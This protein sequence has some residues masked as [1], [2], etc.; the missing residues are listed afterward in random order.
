MGTIFFNAHHS[1]IGAFASF[2][3]G[4]CG[5]KGGLGLELGKPANENLY[6]GAETR[7]GGTFE[8]LPFFAEAEDESKRYD[9]EAQGKTAAKAA[10]RPF[11]RQDIRR[12]FRLGTDTWKA[13]DLTFR[14]LSPVT[15]VPDPKTAGDKEMKRAI[16]PAVLA[17]LTLDNSAGRKPRQVFFGYQGS[18][19]YSSMRRLD[20]TAAGAF[21]GI[22]QGRR[23]AIVS[24][25]PGTVSCLGFTMESIL[26]PQIAANLVFGLGGTGAVVGVV[27]PRQTRTFRFAVCF[28]RDGYCT[29]GIDCS[30]W[31]TRYFANIEAVA[32]YALR[33][34]AKLATT[35]ETANRMVDKAKLSPDQKFQLRHAIRSYYGSTEFLDWDGKPFWVVNEGE[36]R[37]M[38]TFDL[39]A[40]QLF[41]ELRMNPWT[42]RNELAMFLKRFSYFD[43]V[44]APGAEKAH[45]GGLSFTHDMGVANS[46]S[47]PHY[48]SYEL[49]GL[50]GCFSHMTHEQLC[51]WVL[52][53]TSYYAVTRDTKWLKKHLAVL[54]ACFQSLLNRDHH[55]PKRRDGVM[56]L[57]S[58][59]CQGGAEITTYD[60]LDTSLGQSRNNLYMAVKCW[61]CY[62]ALEKLFARARLPTLA[63]ESASQ[64]RRCA[65]TICAHLTDKGYIPAVMGEGNDSKII[66]A[67]EGLV[68]P[69]IQ[70]HREAL[71]PKGRF[72]ALMAALRQHLETVLQPGVCLFPDGGWKMSA[73][74]NNSWL[75]KIYICQFVARQ[76]FGMKWA[77]AGR[78]A[79]AAH[80]AWLLHPESLYWSWSDQIISGIARGSKYYPRGVTS[81]LWL[82]E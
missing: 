28:Y 53:G 10:L 74:S 49:F 7:A 9:V 62:V 1:P 54:K 30:Y 73:T 16:L 64:A 70:G 19:P 44:R 27:P 42:V 48:S 65:S 32:G 39:T 35:A 60:S 43:E 20:D 14:V 38:N 80:V 40:D 33:H 12:D 46:V 23:T 75:S 52:C 55:D 50:D 56:S 18:D 29:A 82:E 24:A 41:F 57:D 58:S 47:R 31:Y 59:R 79:D 15:A 69:W 11:P 21:C 2:T 78:Q 81:I 61:A 66:P 8:A 63:R 5:A 17:E 25:S 68:F 77:A 45:P 13:G 37:M 26:Q 34:F 6:I 4:C 36:Y 3:F 76:V 67:I 72:A 22:G 51:N 71:D